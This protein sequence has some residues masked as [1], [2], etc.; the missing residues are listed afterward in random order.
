M[1]RRA[2]SAPGWSGGNWM[3][4]NYPGAAIRLPTRLPIR[5]P[6]CLPL[7]L[8]FS[9]ASRPRSRRGRILSHAVFLRRS[10]RLSEHL[11]KDENRASN[12]DDDTEASP[13]CKQQATSRSSARR[14]LHCF[15]DLSL[16]NG[17]AAACGF[18]LTTARLTVFNSASTWST[19]HRL[20][21][22]ARLPTC[23]CRVR[24]QSSDRWS[25]RTSCVSPWLRPMLLR[26]TRV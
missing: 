23:P 2:P 9:V 17:K 22:C 6:L 24:R 21:P 14:L 26:P 15:H 18:S 12:H 13:Q 20:Q 19:R 10:G 3:R 25:G 7:R 1:R 4:R 11:G 16:Q 8:P 5:L